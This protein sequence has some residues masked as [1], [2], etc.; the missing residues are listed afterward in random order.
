MLAGIAIQVH[1]PNFGPN[2][3]HFE[4]AGH[5]FIG[6]LIVHSLEQGCVFHCFL[7]VQNH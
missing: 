6:F 1:L 2:L 5:L 7:G 4:I 3:T